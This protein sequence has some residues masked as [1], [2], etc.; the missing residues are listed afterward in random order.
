[1][2]SAAGGYEYDDLYSVGRSLAI[3]IG[4]SLGF[5]GVIGLIATIL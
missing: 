1:M 2:R 3:I 5:W 4:L